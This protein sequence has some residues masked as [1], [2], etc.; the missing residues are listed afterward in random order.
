MITASDSGPSIA[1]GCRY[2]SAAYG[3][4]VS[5]S[6]HTTA[7]SGSSITSG[8]RYLSSAYADIASGFFIAASDSG[9]VFAS[10]RSQGTAAG[11]CQ[12][13]FCGTVFLNSRSFFTCC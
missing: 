9:P 11:N 2:R 1:S 13:T 4:A 10:L 5:G 3:N 6:V 8:C 12:S 7:D